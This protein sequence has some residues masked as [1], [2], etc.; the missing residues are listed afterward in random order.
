MSNSIKVTEIACDIAMSVEL[1]YVALEQ[2]VL[3][4]IVRA[5]DAAREPLER[6]LQR[7]QERREG[8][9]SVPSGGFPT[10]LRLNGR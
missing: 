3:A 1:A 2:D 6:L 8:A 9:W 5:D 10:G 7:L 4:E